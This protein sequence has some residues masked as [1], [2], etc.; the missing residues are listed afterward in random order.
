MIFFTEKRYKN[1]HQSTKDTKI[2]TAILNKNNG[3]EINRFQVYYGAIVRKT[4]WYGYK[5]THAD[6]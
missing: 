4:V 2:D 6:Q 3:E 5:N 1:S